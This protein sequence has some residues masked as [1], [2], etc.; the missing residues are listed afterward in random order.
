M[1]SYVLEFIP[2]SKDA[3]AHFKATLTNVTNNDLEVQVND[4]AFHSTLEITSKSE[5]KIEA[6]IKRYRDLLLTSTWFEPVVTIQSKKSI[7]W[8]VP[9][10]SLLTLHGDEVTRD[11]LAGRQ[12][13]SE[14]VIAVVPQTRSY[15]SDNAVQRSKPITIQPKG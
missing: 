14:M 13:V 12:V 10:T 15:I 7:A 4:K 5:K 8:T 2:A 1:F 3:T 11:L 6:F 9:I